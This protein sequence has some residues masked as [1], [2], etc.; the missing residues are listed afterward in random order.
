[1]TFE[2]SAKLWLVVLEDGNAKGKAAAREE[3][4]RYARELD[5]LAALVGTSFDVEDTPI[6]G[7]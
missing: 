7:E 4:L 5:R 2:G 3:M 6:E 1:M